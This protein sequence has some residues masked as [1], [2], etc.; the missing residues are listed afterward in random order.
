MSSEEH[1]TEN[2]FSYGTLRQEEVQLST[3][4]RKLE[5]QT[6]TLVGYVL[7]MIQIADADFAAKNGAHHRNLEFTGVAS[8][9]VEGMAFA[10]TQQELEQSDKYEPAEYERVPVKLKSGLDAYVYLRTSQR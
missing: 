10:V 9:F 4:G 3:F 8:D 1:V 6:D 5:G 2:L 7:K